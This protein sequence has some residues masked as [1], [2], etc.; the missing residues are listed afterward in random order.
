LVENIQPI[1]QYTQEQYITVDLS[2]AIPL[3]KNLW[4]FTDQSRQ[5]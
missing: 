4:F 2:T 5:P 1:S 3:N